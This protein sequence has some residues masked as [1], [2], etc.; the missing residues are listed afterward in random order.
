MTANELE[1]GNRVASRSGEGMGRLHGGRVVLVGLLWLALVQTAAALD[2]HRPLAQL[3]HTAWRVQDG[4]PGQITA[5]AQTTDGYLWLATQIGLYRFDG[6]QFERYEPPAG[7]ALPATSVSALHASPDGG[8]WVGFRYGAVSHIDGTRLSHYGQAQGLPSGTVFSF[9]RDA[10]GRLWAATFTGLVYLQGG[11]WHALGPRWQYPGRQART[12]FVDAE[13]TLWVAS[14]QGVAYL[15]RGGT[16]FQRV[17]ARVGRI[18]Q[19]A[20]GPDGAIWIAEADGAVRALPVPGRPTPARTLPLASA[21]LLFDRDGALWATTLGDGLYRWT[22]EAASPFEGFRQ[23]KGLTSDYALPLL[24]DM[25]GTLWIG[26]SRGLDRFRHAN[27][28]LAPLPD[29]AHDFAI[30]A[31][32]GA[33]VLVGSRNRPLLRLKGGRQETLPLAPPL[34]AAYRDPTGMVW[35]G[36]PKGIWTLHDGTLAPGVPLPVSRYSGVQAITRTSD[37]SVW[38]SLNTPGLHRLQDGRW[39]HLRDLPGTR[40]GA[41][42]LTL[43]PGADGRVWMGFAHN[44]IA[45]MREGRLQV[46]GLPQGLDVGNVSALQQGRAGLWIGGERGLARM[47]GDR[48]QTLRAQA[49]SP[50]RG[51]SGIVETANGDL[52]LNGARGIVRIPAASIEAVFA[53]TSAAAYDLFDFLDGLPGVPAQFRPIPT[54]LQAGD[55]RL[56]FATTSGVV[57]IDPDRIQ[58]NPLPPPVS[59]HSLSVDG[60]PYRLEA[61]PLRL[62]AGARNL[63]IGYAAL[64]LAIPERVRFRYRLEGYDQEWQE[65]GTRRV[66]YYTNP[67][68]GDY[69]FRVLAANNDGVWNETGARIAFSIAP[70]YYQTTWFAAACVTAA[71]A[72]LWVAYLLRL[73]RVSRQIH[74]R[75]QER[76]RERER[77]ARELHD[78]L[79]QSVQGLILR[80]H[81]VAR[82]L[83]P[84]APARDALD[85]VLERADDVMVEARDRVLDL[86]ATARGGC[87]ADMFA[88]MAAEL[89]AGPELSIR[90]SEEGNRMPIDPIVQDE[91]L[92]IGREAM[93]NACRHA[94]ARHIGIAIAQNAAYLAVSVHDDG[95]G[96]DPDVLDRGGREGHWGLAGMRERAARIGARLDIASG[97]GEGT[98]VE[99]QVPAAVAYRPRTAWWRRRMGRH[100]A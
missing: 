4:A 74:D 8:L 35:L 90:V 39:T 12:V 56:W 44:Q 89:E 14:E 97:P 15:P 2:V 98:R 43:L 55:G 94:G 21:G 72:L 80:F 41:S 95:R 33:A 42:P 59:I 53:G 60:R 51:I 24:E 91:L 29:G 16:Q 37:G 38:V 52:W 32:E 36:G 69:V 9:A 67:G 47:R 83:G 65:A 92:Q 3:H 82:S 20:Q 50:F 64:S 85:A 28:V 10:D 76:H 86:R 27:V 25:E 34:T 54:A 96:I 17:Q 11:R 40:E 19:I 84:G 99:V 23:R 78:T 75:L 31:E 100:R 18:S 5:L 73:R 71:A 62:P 57:T 77:I 87:L 63:Q 30:V 13:G 26:S 70:R 45:S 79:L 93:L 22:G 88:R 1:A 48:I 68:P 66:A 49:D 7:E 6:V 61:G 81:A 58:R 46:F